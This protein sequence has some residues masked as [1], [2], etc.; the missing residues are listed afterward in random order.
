MEETHTEEGQKPQSGPDITDKFLQNKNLLEL[1]VRA[2][3]NHKL[4]SYGIHEG[5]A[6]T[7]H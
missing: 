3:L 1:I 7:I 6:I 5:R 2:H 4:T